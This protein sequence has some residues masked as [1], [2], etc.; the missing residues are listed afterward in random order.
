M[1]HA[2]NTSDTTQFTI[3]ESI[4]CQGSGRFDGRTIIVKI[5]PSEPDSGICFV[6][7]DVAP[8]QSVIPVGWKHL[9]ATH[10]GTV[11]G[12]VHGITVAY[13]EHVLG[14][15]H[16]C[17]IDNAIIE[18]SGMEVAAPDGGPKAL[19][20]MIERVGVVAQHAPLPGIWIEYPLEQTEAE[21][22]CH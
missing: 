10:H 20:V 15:L 12:N 21:N 14:A 4:S 18:L 1:F 9:V 5:H 6:R 2:A 17:G 22:G 16:D 11:L 19:R 13:A 8:G 3:G 7:T